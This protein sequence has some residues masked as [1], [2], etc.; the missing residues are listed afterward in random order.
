VIAA[1]LKAQTQALPRAVNVFDVKVAFDVVAPDGK[2]ER[3][4]V[5]AKVKAI[6]VKRGLKDAS[7][8]E[9]L[10]NMVGSVL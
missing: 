9:A 7:H 10:D 1:K 4:T 6:F 5:G 3:R 2:Q 8:R